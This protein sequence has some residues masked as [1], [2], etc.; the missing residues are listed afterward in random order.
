MAHHTT[1][2]QR[3]VLVHK[4]AA[5]LGVTFEA[6]F[7]LAEES[8]SAALERLLDIGPATFDRDSHVWIV[9]IGAA[10]FAFQHRVVMRHL[11]LRPHFQVTLETGGR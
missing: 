7:V 9:A 6:R 1:F 5:L 11:E 10:H 8:N 2:S 3:L 4:R